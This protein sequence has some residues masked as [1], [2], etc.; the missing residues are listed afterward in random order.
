[1]KHHGVHAVHN[2]CTLHLHERRSERTACTLRMQDSD[3]NSDEAVWSDWARVD[4]SCLTYLAE[5]EALA[6]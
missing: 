3:K 2:D 5:V 6:G 1:M 4:V